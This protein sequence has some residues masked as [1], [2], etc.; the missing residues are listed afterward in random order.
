MLRVGDSFA[1]SDTGR[2][3]RANEDSYFA[4]APLFAVADG[5]GGAQAGEVASRIAV[6]S[7]ADGLHEDGGQGLE[8]ALAALV[9]GANGRIHELSRADESR[10]G[11]GTTMTVVLVG[12]E[13]LTIAHVGDSRA[14]QWRDELLERLTD[15]HSLVEEMLRRGQLTPEA[16]REHP[17]RSIITRA[18]GPEASVAVDTYTHRARDGD[19]LLLCSD[20]LTTMV[21]EERI[22]TLLAESPGLA[23]AGDAL[24]DAANAAGGRDNVTVV[25]LLL[26]EV[27]GGGGFAEADQPT[28]AGADAPRA[29]DVRAALATA[30]RPDPTTTTGS[31]ERMRRL[32]PLA[33]PM[34]PMPQGDEDPLD[35]DGGEATH[36]GG[37]RR[38]TL[39]RVLTLLVVLAFV[40][41]PIG[42]ATILAVNAV[43]FVGSDEQGFVTVYRG[44]PYDLP[45]G[46]DLYEVNYTSGVQRDL[47]P[48]AR[49]ES[50]FDHEMRSRDGAYD[51]VRAIELGRIA[52]R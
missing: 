38:G 34:P 23:E 45:L 33:A 26:D 11:M 6:E 42:I 35:A 24:I 49:R 47:V 20:G 8:R 18:L 30:E 2:Q 44:L 39:R 3:R 27:G 50:V 48:E 51:L 15:D 21:D 12:E 19:V 4:R 28:T 32:E 22:A 29:E 17:Q 25:L 16:A 5:M 1:R 41:V 40:L 36:P 52:T 37:R 46:L 9:E 14:Y 13:E 10:A 31:G 7:L 43:Y